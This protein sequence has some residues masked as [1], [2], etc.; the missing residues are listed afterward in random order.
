MKNILDIIADKIEE[1]TQ[2]YRIVIGD[3]PETGDVLLVSDVRSKGLNEQLDSYKSTNKT[4]KSFIQLYVR[5]SS[6]KFSYSG[7]YTDLLFVSSILLG[8]CH[9]TI[10]G[11][12][13][14]DVIGSDIIYLGKDAKG[15]LIFS[16][17]FSIK[18]SFNLV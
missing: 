9:Q 4:Q 8:T 1:Y 5:A 14:E 15:N 10:D 17:K 7:V 3:L 6:S 2:S 13:V 18:Y 12:T 11:V 16:C